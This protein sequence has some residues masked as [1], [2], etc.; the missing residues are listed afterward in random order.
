MAWQNLITTTLFGRRFGLQQLTTSQS[1]GRLQ[2]D[3]L[4]GAEQV[5][6]GVTTSETTGNSLTAY[7]VSFLTAT[8]AGSSLVYTLDPPIPGVTK[9]LYIGS[10]ANGPFYVQVKN[11]ATETIQSTQQ[12]SGTVLKSSSP[13][14]LQL[15]G[16]TTAIWAAIGLTSGTSSN[17]AGFALSTTT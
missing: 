2:A 10:S 7:G 11:V 16:I 3:F 5:R 8:T 6:I 13:G 15:I 17:A 9:T 1:G 14:A 4:T 12:T